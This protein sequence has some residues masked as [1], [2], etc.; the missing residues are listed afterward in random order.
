MNFPHFPYC[1]SFPYEP[2]NR[3]NKCCLLYTKQT[4]KIQQPAISL[5]CEINKLF[6]LIVNICMLP[7]LNRK[8]FSYWDTVESVSQIEPELCVFEEIKR[9]LTQRG[10]IPR[11]PCCYICEY[12]I[13]YNTTTLKQSV[14]MVLSRQISL[15]QLQTLIST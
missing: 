9:T 3:S 13:H 8:P 14:L 10:S 2:Y 11:P 15:F 7:R 1:T 6:G 4:L 12:N 5:F